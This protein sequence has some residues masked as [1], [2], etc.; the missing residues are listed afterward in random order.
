[1]KKAV[2]FGFLLMMSVS[3]VFAGFVSDFVDF[4]DRSE[5]PANQLGIT[6]LPG[7]YFGSTGVNEFTYTHDITFD[8]AAES[9][10]AATL[11]L[12][13]G[14]EDPLYESGKVTIG[15]TSKDL[16]PDAT[17]KWAWII[18]YTD[19]DISGDHVFDVK[20]EISS[21]DGSYDV[22]VTRT[23]TLPG[24]NFR[25]LSSTLAVDYNDAPASVPEPAI[26]SLLGVGLLGLAGIARKN[27]G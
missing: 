16:L 24:Q 27:R 12:V 10:N 11:T 7:V 4:S 15:L 17:T 19:Y 13:L 18:P 6:D 8:P 2:I 3:S 14:D 1:M 9:I 25:L 22:T 21:E 5:F 23:S 26:V 20:A